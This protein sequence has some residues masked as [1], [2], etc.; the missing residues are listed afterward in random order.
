MLESDDYDMDETGISWKSDRENKFAQV[1]GFKKKEGPPSSNCAAMFGTDPK[2]SDCGST[3]KDGKHYWYWYPANSKTKY[4][5]EVYPD[6]VNPIDGVED[7]HFIVW[8]RTAGL[9][10]FRKP[11]GRIKKKIPKGTQ[12][13]F[14]VTASTC[15]P[16]PEP[17][18]LSLTGVIATV[19]TLMCPSLTVPR[20]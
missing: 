16:K 11:Y 15:S 5:Y 9:P 10:E 19:Q 8:M 7:E 20:V 6:I 13:S 1:E 4:L 12:L 17:H 3:Y 14:N 2:Y 18:S